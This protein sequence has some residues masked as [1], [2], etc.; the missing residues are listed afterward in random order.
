[1][2]GFIAESGLDR[3]EHKFGGNAWTIEAAERSFP[4]PSLLLTLDTRD[5][6]LGFVTAIPEI[7]LCSRLDGFSIA[8]QLYSFDVNSH[9]VMFDGPAWHISLDPEDMLASPLPLRNLY[10]RPLRHDEDDEKAS[11]YAVQDTFLGGDAFLR[12]RGKPLWLLDPE[13]V[14]CLCGKEAEFIASIGYEN[15][16][17]PSGL[18]SPV[19]PFFIG[20]LA[21]Y[22]FGCLQCKRIVVV[23]QPS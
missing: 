3:Y 17:R 15:Y 2:K 7:P 6:R 16:A 10:L 19:R 5:P 9:R 8:R 22:F 23:S 1:M 14:S 11:K 4:S 12:I 13:E 18:I 20:E 21:L